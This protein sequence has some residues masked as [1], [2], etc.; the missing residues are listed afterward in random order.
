[1]FVDWPKVATDTNQR[2]FAA[3]LALTLIVDGLSAITALWISDVDP[4][5]HVTDYRRCSRNDITYLIYI[6]APIAARIILMDV[7]LKYNSSFQP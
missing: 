3:G 1:M 7:S 2:F 4:T 5:D 6:I